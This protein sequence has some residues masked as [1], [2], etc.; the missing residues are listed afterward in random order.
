MRRYPLV[1]LVTVM[2]MVLWYGAIR[3]AAVMRDVASEMDRMEDLAELAPRPQATIV[4]DRRGDPVFSY[5]V[6]QRIDVR[7]ADV[8][9]VMLDALLA[10]EDKRYFS[11]NGLDPV[12]IAGAAWR[13]V[14]ARRIVQGGSTITQQL[15]RVSQ[16]SPVRTYARKVRE[17]LLAANIEQRYSKEQILEQYLNTVYFG[18]GFYGV[19]AAARGYFQ[20][21]ASALAAHEAALLAAL[22]RSPSHDSPF[23][24]PA[25]AHTRRNLVLQLMVRQGKL[26]HGQATEAAAAPLPD[27]AKRRRAGGVLLAG[28]K[29]SG[30]YFQEELRQQLVQL[31]GDERVLRGGLRVYSTYDP[32]MQQA[33]EQAI[34]GRIAQITARNR[35][36][37]ELQGSLVAMD[38]VTGDVYAMV[39]G[40]D[41]T[42]SQFNRATQAKRQAGS[43]FKPIVFAA[44]LERGYAPGTM[45]RELDTPIYAGYERK[46]WLPAGNHERSE[47]TLRNALTASS[48]RA[49]AHLMQRL[50]VSSAI[51]YASRL[52][53]RSQLPSVPSLALGT[54]EVTLL[55]LTSAYTAFAAQ[56]VAVAPRLMTHVEDADGNLLWEAPPQ[57][58]QA[59]SPTTAYLMSHMLG[60]IVSHGLASGARAAGFRLP[61][62]GKTGT[63]DDYADT[64]FIGYT[65]RL[66][67]GVWFGLDERA[68]IMNEGWAATVA[69][70]AWAHFMRLA[71]AGAKADWYQRPA[72]VE[73][74]A[75]CSLSGAR[76]TDACRRGWVAAE[77]DPYGLRSVS[78]GANAA[79]SIADPQAEPLPVKQRASY[80]YEDLFPLGAIPTEPCWMHSNTAPTMPGASTILTASPDASPHTPL[81]DDALRQQQSAASPP[82]SQSGTQPQPTAQPLPQPLPPPPLPQAPKAA[83]PSAIPVGTTGVVPNLPANGTE[84]PVIIEG[85]NGTRFSVQK[86]VGPDG[87]VRTV[88]KQIR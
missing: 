8:S 74:V 42:E 60:Q 35:K 33:A 86:V 13:N 17:A 83:E 3:A 30:L 79:G 44:A 28:A 31:F 11:H 55:E 26:T 67:A 5:F 29:G 81:V 10:V 57:R 47:Y 82:M 51:Y 45:L 84:A 4:L 21:P 9:P 62:A 25:R 46:P 22:V 72:D 18:E 43:A 59:L 65:P 27:P 6:E 52:G 32:A 87:V 49:A 70:P 53:I 38:A 37:R 64:W 7:I 23:V 39:G 40:R 24:A 34:T 1:A 19:E 88:V 14:K 41:F 68:P 66:V 77:P 12:R 16:L 15:A 76:A 69:V 54:G 56:G 58:S 36:A 75:V 85:S 50:G 48:N 73:V 20:K 71:T 2:A 63:T 80:V 61:A 78:T